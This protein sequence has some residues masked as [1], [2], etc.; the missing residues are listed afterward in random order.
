MLAF[1]A[2]AS[3]TLGVPFRSRIFG[4][5]FGFGVIA[6]NNMVN[7]LIIGRNASLASTAELVSEGVYFAAIRALGWVFPAAGAGTPSGHHARYITADALERRCPDPGQSSWAGCGQLSAFVYD[8]RVRSGGKRD[9][10]D[11]RAAKGNG[12]KS[13]GTDRQLTITAYKKMAD[14]SES[15]IYICWD[16]TM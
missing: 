3:Q 4:V 6:V 2:F 13:T 12:S 10:A 7:S 8:R 15:A 1:L 11:R 16:V 14:S 9:G 5:T